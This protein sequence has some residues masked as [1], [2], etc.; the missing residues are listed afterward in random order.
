MAQRLLEANAKFIRG[1]SGLVLA[2]I[3]SLN[4]NVAR[5]APFSG[6]AYTP[7]PTFLQNKKAIVNVHNDDNQCFGYAIASALHPIHHTEHPTRPE[8]Y[9]QYFEEH[10]LNDIEYPVNPVDIPQR[11][12]RLNLSINLYSYFDDIG[13]ASHPMYISRHNSP[14]QIDMLYF[15]GHY[16][17]IKDLSRLFN[18]LTKRNHQTIF[19]KRCL[20]HFRLVSAFERHQQLCTREAYISTL[21]ILPEPESTIKY[22]NWKYMTWAPFL[23]YADL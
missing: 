23:I 13:K 5:V 3:Y 17:W 16:A 4:L 12:E 14:I 1:K 22:T 2:E 10:R 19:C 7:L 15:N 8:N 20:G 6:S 9:L 18:D 21:H 11:E